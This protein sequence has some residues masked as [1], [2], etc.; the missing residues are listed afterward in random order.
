MSKE[1]KEKLLIFDLPGSSKMKF[2]L[3]L[4]AALV[5]AAFAPQSALAQEYGP[6]DAASISTVQ[7]VD[8]PE[9]D[10]EEDDDPLSWSF[11]LTNELHAYNNLDMRPLNED[12]LLTIRETDDRQNLGYTSVSAGVS[13]DLREDTPFNFGGALSGLWGSDQIGTTTEFGA[14]IYVDDLSVDWTAVDTGAFSLSTTLGRQGFSIGGADEDF[15]FKDIVDG[16]TLNADFGAAGRIRVLVIDVFGEAGRPENV[17]FARFIGSNVQTTN[18]FR[19]D[20]DVYRYGG[21]YELLD[22]V[23]AVDLRAFA[24]GAYIGAARGAQVEEATTGTDISSIGATAN[25]ADDDYNFMYGGRANYTFDADD[26]EIGVMAEYAR[27]QGLD[28]KNTKLGLY[29]VNTD[30]NAFGAG[31]NVAADLGVVDLDARFRFFRAEGSSYTGEEGLLFSHGF[32]SMKGSEVGGINI[33][34]YAGWHPSSYV[35]GF[36]GIADTPQDLN[37]KAGTQTLHGGLG[38]QFA[39]HVRLDLDAWYYQDTSETNLDTS[40]V[41]DIEIPEAWGIN[42]SE[43]LAQ[44]RLGKTLG[45]ELNAAL[46]YF[47]NDALSLYAIGGIFMPGEFYEMSINL[48]AG[49]ALGAVDN[50]PDQLQTFWVAAGGATLAF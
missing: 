32:T 45:T 9:D 36:E 31:A 6:D 8:E 21:V 3:F 7:E 23:D 18:N 42:E 49:T 27:S 28:R 4:L 1:V 48:T 33:S 14:P 5:G 12:N 46:T 39:E 50:D 26:F 24:F 34:R 25:F 40:R 11:R 19:G 29:D 37:R 15:F 10:E 35:S 2:K 30:G 43:L 20:T 22:L 44:D 41:E 16:V 17:D 47:A 13:Y 38:F